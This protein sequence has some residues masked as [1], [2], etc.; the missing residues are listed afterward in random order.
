MPPCTTGSGADHAL[1]AC[2]PCADRALTVVLTA[3]T[4]GPGAWG[5]AD[6]LELG[7]PGEGVLTWEESKAHLALSAVT[8]QPLFLSNDLRPGSM[9]RRLLARDRLVIDW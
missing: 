3:C 7:V 9:Q 1:T 5:F 2:W 8:S 4:T 6:S